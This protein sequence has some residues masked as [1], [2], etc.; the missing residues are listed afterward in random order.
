M[1]NKSRK[2]KHHDLVRGIMED[3]RKV[4][5]GFAVKIPLASAEGVSVINLRSA[6]MRAAEKENFS[7]G[8]SADDKDFY[9]WKS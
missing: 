7:I 8:T 5:A 1:L 9:V 3:L 6:I 2:G 4:E